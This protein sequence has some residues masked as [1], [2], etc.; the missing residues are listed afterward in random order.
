[1][2]E[3]EDNPQLDDD[4]RTRLNE[5]MLDWSLRPVRRSEAPTL[6]EPDKP[7]SQMP[8]LIG[9]GMAEAV[10]AG[11][12]LAQHMG[13]W[14]KLSLL[15]L[16]EDPSGIIGRGGQGV[17]DRVPA[18]GALPEETEDGCRVAL[19]RRRC[20]VDSA[21]AGDRG[22]GVTHRYRGGGSGHGR[23]RSPGCS[24]AIH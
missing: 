20:D 10:R 24:G 23:Q 2:T 18:L 8:T 7:V 14:Q 1:M 17:V 11:P 6:V 12:A 22:R 19:G 16:L 5:S 9:P 3:H 21:E 13:D 4:L 15:P